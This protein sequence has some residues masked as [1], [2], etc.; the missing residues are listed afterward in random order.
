MN[1]LAQRTLTPA[2]FT[3]E[4]GQVSLKSDSLG[5]CTSFWKNQEKVWIDYVLPAAV[6]SEPVSLTLPNAYV[7][8]CSALLFF[9]AKNKDAKL[10]PEFPVLKVSFE[11]LDIGEQKHQAV[12]DIALHLIAFSGEGQFIHGY[13][14][15]R[16]AP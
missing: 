11:Y 8:L 2:Y 12:F 14:E 10:F 1:Q 15:S 6:Q 5:G 16:K 7:L 13:L 9:G 3:Y 4:S